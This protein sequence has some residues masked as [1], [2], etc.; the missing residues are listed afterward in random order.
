MTKNTRLHSRARTKKTA[1]RMSRRLR[2]LRE[3]AVQRL[4][5]SA[6]LTEKIFVTAL[7]EILQNRIENIPAHMM[8]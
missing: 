4:R 6:D 7:Y 3:D 8:R 2:S 5:Q 1:L